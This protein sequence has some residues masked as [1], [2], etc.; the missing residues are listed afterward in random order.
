MHYT[1]RVLHSHRYHFETKHRHCALYSKAPFIQTNNA[2]LVLTLKE[3]LCFAPDLSK[4]VVLKTVHAYKHPGQEYKRCNICEGHI[5]DEQVC[6]AAHG[7]I[8]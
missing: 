5:G 8:S 3:S 2:Q 7:T 1:E 4:Y 6:G